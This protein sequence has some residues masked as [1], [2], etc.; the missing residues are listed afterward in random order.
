MQ[1]DQISQVLSHYIITRDSYLPF[2]PDTALVHDSRFA[3]RSVPVPAMLLLP[4]IVIS[5]PY[6]EE[7]IASS[8]QAPSSSKTPSEALEETKKWLEVKVREGDAPAEAL[9]L[10]HVPKI[11]HHLFKLQRRSAELT[12]SFKLINDTGRHILLQTEACILRDLEFEEQGAIVFEGDRDMLFFLEHVQARDNKSDDGPIGDCG[13]VACDACVKSESALVR[14]QSR[15]RLEFLFE[16]LS[17][18]QQDTVIPEPPAAPQSS[19]DRTSLLADL[20]EGLAL[21]VMSFMNPSDLHRLSMTCQW[22]R[23]H[24]QRGGVNLRLHPHQERAIVRMLNREKNPGS[25][26]QTAYEAIKVKNTSRACYGDMIDGSIYAGAIPSRKDF[27]GGL[28]CDEPGKSFV[29][30]RNAS[31][32]LAPN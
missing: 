24:V 15:F 14:L 18:E 6:H 22:W 26:A 9:K 25:C 12:V 10:V 29:P 3:S 21:R 32:L 23:Y 1:R 2:F 7:A 5:L 31:T 8:S 17:V 19:G 20:P 16:T 13:V 4:N 30:V 28:F 27:R 11:L